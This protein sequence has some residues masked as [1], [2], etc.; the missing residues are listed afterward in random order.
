MFYFWRWWPRF[1]LCFSIVLFFCTTVTLSDKISNS[2]CE[3]ITSSIS[4]SLSVLQ[5]L[6]PAGLHTLAATLMFHSLL[7]SFSVWYFNQSGGVASATEVCWTSCWFQLRKS[8]PVDQ[9]WPC[10]TVSQSWSRACVY[11][12]LSKEPHLQCSTNM[13]VKWAKYFIWAL[14]CSCLGT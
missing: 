3:W 10:S 6:T 14:P 8:D 1:V 9:R 2:E 13:Q 12:Q 4:A 5:V 7:F 11:L